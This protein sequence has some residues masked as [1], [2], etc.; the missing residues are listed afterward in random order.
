[1]LNYCIKNI[2]LKTKK[3]AK[4]RPNPKKELNYDPKNQKWKNFEEFFDP[5]VYHVFFWK[6]FSQNMKHKYVFQMKLEIWYIK[7]F[8]RKKAR[9]KFHSISFQTLKSCAKNSAKTWNANTFFRWKVKSDTLIDYSK[10]KRAR[11]FI[12]FH[13]KR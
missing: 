4:L 5:I 3:R 11:F 1:M 2:F 8:F 6:N 9:K 7:R 10:K 12:P 13:S